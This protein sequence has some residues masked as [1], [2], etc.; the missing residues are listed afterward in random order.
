MSIYSSAERSYLVNVAQSL[1]A[2]VNDKYIKA[3]QPIL[4]C[5]KPEGAKYEGAIKW[6][7][8][9]LT[10]EWLCNCLKEKRRINEIPYLVGD[11]IP[12]KKNKIDEIINEESS[13]LNRKNTAE[14]DVKENNPHV[15]KEVLDEDN[16]IT[17]PKRVRELA[18][19]KSSPKTPTATLSISDV[20]KFVPTPHR[21]LLYD[22]LKAME[23]TP[24]TKKFRKLIATPVGKNG[25][26]PETK[27]PEMPDC[28]RTEVTPYGFR[29]DASPRNHEMHKRRFQ[30]L[31][32]YY[33]P[34]SDSKRR[35]SLTPLSEVKRRF[36]KNAFGDEYDS[37]PSIDN[38]EKPSTSRQSRRENNLDVTNSISRMNCLDD[39][40][41]VDENSANKSGSNEN[42]K[43]LS[44]FIS[45]SREQTSKNIKL[46][47]ARH[48]SEDHNDE[49]KSNLVRI[50]TQLLDLDTEQN[51]KDVDWRDPD[52]FF[53]SQRFQNKSQTK[54]I[55]L[56]SISNISPDS[57]RDDIIAKIIQLGGEV[58]D[59]V[60]DDKTTHIFCDKLN[61]G[62]KILSAIA[63]GKWILS[64]KYV[65]DSAES[66]E[67]LNVITFIYVCFFFNHYK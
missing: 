33:Q 1:G 28:L 46:E 41:I 66:Q 50:D 15:V 10:A 8:A 22:T 60:F 51:N 59:H 35:K 48:I 19:E 58:L 62:E 16:F 57:R 45:K 4:I 21:A 5:P 7:N 27:T 65:E 55:V 12:S 17:R 34:I 47:R 6:G 61:R 11:S 42:V 30:V 14:D 43:R 32:M 36:W 38:D 31:D 23:E 3:A 63:S 56:C 53:Q 49:E 18:T 44:D 67:F 9:V 24:N 2:N 13:E 37:S 54:K 40:S 64:S 25:E 20:V 29:P 26:I 52:D 39:D